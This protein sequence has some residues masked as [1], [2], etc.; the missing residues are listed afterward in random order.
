M[1]ALRF[2]AILS[3]VAGT[4]AAGEGRVAWQHEGYTKL[5]DAALDARKSGRR[6]LVGVPG[7]GT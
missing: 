1:S 7:A 3:I 4:V 5:F 6:I 2:A